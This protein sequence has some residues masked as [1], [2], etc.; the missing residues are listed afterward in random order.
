MKI[1]RTVLLFVILLIIVITFIVGKIK[2][3]KL[4]V[5][6]FFTFLVSGFI[7][8]YLISIVIHLFI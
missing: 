4:P 3:R 1:L 7:L 2:K 5:K 6:K 8:F